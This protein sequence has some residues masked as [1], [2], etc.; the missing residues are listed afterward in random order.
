[1]NSFLS[2]ISSLYGINL[3]VSRYLCKTEFSHWRRP[4]R[5][6]R[7]AK[8]WRKR[9]GAVMKP[10]PGVAYQIAGMGVVSCPCI[11]AKICEVEL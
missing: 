8:K 11:A 5:K 2:A 6:K 9:Y 10:C 7:I 4:H 3:T 1:M